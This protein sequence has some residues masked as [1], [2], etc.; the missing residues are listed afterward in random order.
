MYNGYF[1]HTTAQVKYEYWTSDFFHRKKTLNS[2]SNL[3]CLSFLVSPD[4]NADAVCLFQ[5]SRH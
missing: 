3:Y 1:S 2:I 4:K 5:F